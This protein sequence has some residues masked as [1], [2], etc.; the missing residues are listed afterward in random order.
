MR[1]MLRSSL[2]LT[3]V[4]LAT[5][6]ACDRRDT[7]GETRRCDLVESIIPTDSW[8][9]LQRKFTCGTGKQLPIV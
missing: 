3:D 7:T 4:P 1:Q 6:T 2:Q 9:R 8:K 5:A